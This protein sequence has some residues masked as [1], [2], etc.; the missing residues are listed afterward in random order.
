MDDGW[1]PTS[2]SEIPVEELTEEEHIR[3]TCE[4]MLE[5]LQRSYLEVAVNYDNCTRIV[6]N[7]NTKWYQDFCACY[8]S[9]SWIYRNGKKTK[10]KKRPRTFIKRG[11]TIA[12]LKR[13]INGDFQGEYADRLMGIVEEFWTDYAEGY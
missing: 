11:A 5:Y 10:N 7:Q 2:E 12:A 9:V 13:M 8:Q 3:M 6:I 4:M 1:G